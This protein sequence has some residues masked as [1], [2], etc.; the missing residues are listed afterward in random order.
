M[1]T[2]R[3]TKTMKNPTL[4]A[5]RAI[6]SMALRRFLIIATLVVVVIW[7]LYLALFFWLV[8]DNAWWTL[9]IILALPLML[10]SGGLVIGGWILTNYLRPRLLSK[11]EKQTITAFVDRFMELAELPGTPQFL[12][13]FRLARDALGRRKNSFLATTLKNSGRLKGDF[14]EIR[15]FFE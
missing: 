2:V 1:E 5:L 3:Y 11:H 12:I 8:R 10:V 9:A 7:V 14:A 6:T 15:R 4:L 13:I